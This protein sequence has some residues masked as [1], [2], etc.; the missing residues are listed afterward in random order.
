MPMD[1]IEALRTRQSCRRFTTEPVP[2]EVIRQI[3][4]AAR[5][6]PSG[7][8]IQ[9]WYVHVMTGQVLQDLINKVQ[10]QDHLF[11][12]GEGA[13][14]AVHPPNLKEPYN[15]RRIDCAVDMYKSV[16]VGRDDRAG[17][18]QQ[19]V[20]NY[21]FFGAPVGLVFTLD[22]TMDVGHWGDVGMFIQ[23]I[24]LAARSHGL[25]TCP[26]QAWISWPK[27]IAEHLNIPDEHMIYCGMALGH[28][29]HDHPIN[30]WRTDRQEV[31]EFTTF[32]GFDDATQSR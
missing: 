2:Q 22:R 18:V 28:M 19:F 25:H 5:W 21:Q 9:P 17:R 23:S 26:Q 30:N 29:D 6:S 3:L 27:T 24:M 14:Y 7:S 1:V 10:A 16:G 32:L 8:N 31:E 13:E 20:D 12:R 15:R 4:D 11:P